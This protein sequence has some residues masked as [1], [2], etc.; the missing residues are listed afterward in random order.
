M[1]NY[2]FSIHLLIILFFSVFQSCIVE[3]ESS[4]DYVVVNG[5]DYKILIERYGGWD[6]NFIN[7]DT[8]F[9][10][11]GSEVVLNYSG[12]GG[13]FYPFYGTDSLV[14]KSGDK[15]KQTY[16]PMMNGKSPFNIDNYEGG[17]VDYKHHITS[18]EY[19]YRMENIDFV[20]Q[21]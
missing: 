13:V 21:E 3:E 14:L 12:K 16:T 1:I 11:I 9:L 17:K 8:I 2:K 5:T 4:V 6:Y 10:E 15:F 7:G 19:T 20:M 18:Y